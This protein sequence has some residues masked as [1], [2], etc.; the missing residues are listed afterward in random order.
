MFNGL[1]IVSFSSLYHIYVDLHIVELHG[2]HH[3]IKSDLIYKWLFT[4][5]FND[6]ASSWLGSWSLSNVLMDTENI[7]FP[8]NDMW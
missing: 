7:R 5:Q 2:A 3:E 4:D 6:V 1:M 8:D